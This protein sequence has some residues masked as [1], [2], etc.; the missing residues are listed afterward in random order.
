MTSRPIR[1]QSDMT[2]MLNEFR[3]Q[4]LVHPKAFSKVLENYQG[5]DPEDKRLQWI[6]SHISLN[7]K[8]ALGTS[9]TTPIVILSCLSQNPARSVRE[10]VARNPNSPTDAFVRLGSDKSKPVRQCVAKNMSTPAQVIQSLT[11]DP[12]VDIRIT[13]AKRPNLSAKVL[14]RLAKDGNWQ[15][16][17]A[18]ADQEHLP[19]EV[20]KTLSQDKA[21]W[22]Q[23]KASRKREGLPA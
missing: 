2:I 19:D 6:L 17:R 1:A 14:K 3:V 5:L 11:K 8:V 13:L 10:N 18:L 22:I 16:R 4:L 7:E 9:L 12:T 20:L 21:W 15:V 23:R